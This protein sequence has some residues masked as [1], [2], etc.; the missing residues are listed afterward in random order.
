MYHIYGI[1]WSNA[2]SVGLYNV[3]NT[4]SVNSRGVNAAFTAVPILMTDVEYP[5]HSSS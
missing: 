1:R 5:L 2:Q 3:P 4:I